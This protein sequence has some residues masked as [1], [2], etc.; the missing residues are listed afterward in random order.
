M[1][2]VLKVF[3]ILLSILLL[4]ITAGCRSGRGSSNRTGSV[5]LTWE[6]PTLRTDGT[7]FTDLAGYNIYYTT[8]PEN[9]TDSVSIDVGNVTTYTI[10]NLPLNTY[11]FVATAYDSTGDESTFSSEVS[12]VIN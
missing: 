11:Y 8:V 2:S 5:V 10:N 3:T 6:A 9:Y 12:K 1:L 4:T 7:P